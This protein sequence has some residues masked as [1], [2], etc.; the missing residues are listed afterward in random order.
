MEFT[1]E[2]VYTQKTFTTMARA[3]RKTIRKKKSKRSHIFGWLVVV[4]G[5]V[6]LFAVHLNGTSI[7][8]STIVTVT[9]MAAIVL[10]TFFEDQINGYVALKRTMPGTAQMTATFHAEGFHTV[11]E[12]GNTDWNYD[13]ILHIAETPEY[14]V[15]IFSVNHAQLH[16]K[17]TISGG[18]AEAFRSFIEMKT[19]K[20][21]ELI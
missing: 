11:T 16:D 9:A 8:P 20:T 21:V 4:L 7:K 19:G 17:R 2:T 14:F 10:V 5:A 13:K 3:L 15:F 6:L 12:I 1:M 18:T